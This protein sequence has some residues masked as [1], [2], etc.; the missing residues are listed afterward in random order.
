ML[1]LKKKEFYLKK[2]IKKEFK[3]IN[4]LGKVYSV[5][6]INSKKVLKIIK[7]NKIKYLFVFGTKKINLELFKTFKN[8]F[9]NFHGGDPER[10]RGLDSHYWAIYH[11]DFNSIKVCMHKIDKKL[12]TGEI[13]FIKKNFYKRKSRNLQIKICLHKNLYKFY[14]KA[15]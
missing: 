14:K 4:F 9:F 8:K 7:T 2:K 6:D 12:D 13:V 11:N 1:I 10:Y 15:N 5:D 3:K